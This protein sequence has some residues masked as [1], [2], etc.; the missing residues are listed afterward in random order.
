MEK[1]VAIRRN[2]FGLVG[3]TILV[4][5]LHRSSLHDG[6]EKIP[7]LFAM[8]IRRHFGPR[9]LIRVMFQ[10]GQERAVGRT[11]TSVLVHACK[12]WIGG[13][14]FLPIRL[15]ALLDVQNIVD[16]GPKAVHIQIPQLLDGVINAI[17]EPNHI[18]IL[19]D[20]NCRLEFVRLGSVRGA[21]SEIMK[22]DIR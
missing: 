4:T 19:L 22:D 10:Q 11:A 5:K 3:V 7:A 12:E 20:L 1:A 16:I 17:M 6:F 2:F 13:V 18:D 9:L 21:E 15:F 8:W 14:V